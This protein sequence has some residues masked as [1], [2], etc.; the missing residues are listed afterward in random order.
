MAQ[1]IQV[2]PCISVGIQLEKDEVG[3]TSHFGGVVA[4]FWELRHPLRVGLGAPLG[5]GAGGG[6]GEV[7]IGDDGRRHRGR[8]APAGEPEHH[9]VLVP[10]LLRVG[11]DE[12]NRLDEVA[13]GVVALRLPLLEPLVGLGVPVLIGLV[14]ANDK[15]VICRIATP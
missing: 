12:G 7:D 9:D 8:P 14:V 4:A 15:G 11:G 3:P 6:D 10:Q 1:K 5:H 13:H 2:G